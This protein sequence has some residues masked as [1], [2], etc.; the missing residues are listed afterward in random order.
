MA[1]VRACSIEKGTVVNTA[2]QWTQEKHCKEWSK[3]LYS[4]KRVD[5]KLGIMRYAD[6][7]FIK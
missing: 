2:I 5:R 3:L 7:Y 4:G 1:Y 6:V